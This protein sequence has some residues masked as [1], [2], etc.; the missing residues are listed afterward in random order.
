MILGS[1]R[2]GN[3]PLGAVRKL[4]EYQAERDEKRLI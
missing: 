1:G 2:G 4:T 3:V